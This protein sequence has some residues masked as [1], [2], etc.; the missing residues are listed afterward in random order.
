MLAHW[1]QSIAGHRSVTSFAIRISDTH[2]TAYKAQLWDSKCMDTKHSWG[3]RLVLAL[4]ASIFILGQGHISIVPFRGAHQK[5][6][7][8]HPISAAY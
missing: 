5:C 4:V 6:H 3:T 2:I 1:I 7:T 8:V